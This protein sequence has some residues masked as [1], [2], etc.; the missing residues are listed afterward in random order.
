M[1]AG[2]A[3]ILQFLQESIKDKNTQIEKLSNNNLRVGTLNEELSLEI[4]QLKQKICQQ[5][6]QMMANEASNNL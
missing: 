2:K 5:Q 1:E 3:R 6:G 4:V